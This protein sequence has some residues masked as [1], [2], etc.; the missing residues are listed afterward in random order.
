VRYYNK[1]YWN[2][3]PHSY[4]NVLHPAFTSQV[5]CLSLHADTATHAYAP[6]IVTVF[7]E[8]RGCIVCLEM[9]A[10]KLMRRLISGELINYSVV[11]TSSEPLRLS[12]LTTVRK[13]P[14]ADRKWSLSRA[15]WRKPRADEPTHGEVP[16]TTRNL[17]QLVAPHHHD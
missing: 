1:H 3:C 17:Q 6:S 11:R 13:H 9:R 14:I 10:D 8:K 12:T 7:E 15:V 4:L 2:F 5:Q 16:K